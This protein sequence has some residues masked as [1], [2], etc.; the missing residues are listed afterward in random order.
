M[1]ESEKGKSE[2]G[3]K[4]EKRGG[5]RNFDF[6]IGEIYLLLSPDLVLLGENFCIHQVEYTQLNERRENN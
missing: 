1:S 2:K 5:K 3:N 6:L 4:E